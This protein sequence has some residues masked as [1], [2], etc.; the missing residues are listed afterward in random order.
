MTRN[1]P[2]CIAPRSRASFLSLFYFFVLMDLNLANM[3]VAKDHKRP[4][5][6]NGHA[7]VKVKRIY[8]LVIKASRVINKNNVGHNKKHVIT[9]AVNKMAMNGFHFFT[10]AFYLLDFN[11]A[12]KLRTLCTNLLIFSSAMD[13]AFVVAYFIN[14]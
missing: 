5:N 8:C 10:V 13:F 4:V 3:N 12:P 1:I 7:S 9:N 14:F 6:V 2:I 11:V